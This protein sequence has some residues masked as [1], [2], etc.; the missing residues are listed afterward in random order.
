MGSPDDSNPAPDRPPADAA[1]LL[2]EPAHLLR[3]SR[4][5]LAA[6]NAA[7]PAEP[8]LEIAFDETTGSYQLKISEQ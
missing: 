4:V 8:R 1:A 2:T 7:V 3:P 5:S 6:A